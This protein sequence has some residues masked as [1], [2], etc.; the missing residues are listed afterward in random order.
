MYNGTLFLSYWANRNLIPNS[1][2][3]R[4]SLTAPSGVRYDKFCEGL[5]PGWDLKNQ[6]SNGTIDFREFSIK[7]LEKISSDDKSKSDIAFIEGILEQGQDVILYCYE[8]DMP[9]HRFI[10]GEL[11]RLNGYNVKQLFGEMIYDW[12]GFGK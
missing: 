2:K 8:K 5:T 11:F 9:C 10:I 1:V 3:I 6:L 4:V 7:Y 12:K